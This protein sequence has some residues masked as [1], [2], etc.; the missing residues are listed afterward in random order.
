MDARPEILFVVHRVPY[1][2]NRGDRIRSYHILRF[3]AARANISLA[4]LTDEALEPDTIETL[5]SCCRQV[6][7]E[8]L[9]RTRWCRAA[10]SLASGRSATEGLFNSP[11]LRATIRAWSRETRWDAVVVYCSSMVPYLDLPE[12]QDIP[13]IVDLVDVD[14][15]KFLDYAARGNGLKKWLHQ[16]EGHR[17]RRLER[18]L[19]GRTHAIC[20]TTEIEADLYRRICPND[21]TH[22]VMNG[23]DLE[24][25]QP[26]PRDG[27]PDRCVF[28]GA[29]DYQPNVDGVT[30]FCDQVWQ[31]IRASRPSATFAIVGRNPTKAVR[32]LSRLQGVE[33]IGNVADVR[34]HLADAQIAVAPLRMARGV[35]NKVLEAMA[36]A[37]PVICSPAA[38]EG[39]EAVAKHDLYECATADQWVQTLR[40]LFDDAAER[41]RLGMHAR[42]YVERQHCWDICLAPLARIIKGIASGNQPHVFPPSGTICSI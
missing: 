29:M 9:D 16:W 36:A 26:A 27:R 3:L 20:L 12:L 24:Y 13:A 8:R 11:R 1:P 4:T 2:P 42:E 23:V 15:E 33:V 25:F 5:E 6:A 21:R 19:P 39:L 22:A 28:V 7:V 37:M 17:L 10:L 32:S 41:K 30:W 38:R 40:S 18:S 34:P 35:Q 14:S 31:P